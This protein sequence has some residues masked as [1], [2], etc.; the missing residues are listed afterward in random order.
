LNNKRN[1]KIKL[2]IDSL[3]EKFVAKCSTGNWIVEKKIMYLTFF[4]HSEESDSNL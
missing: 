2:D 1:K 3:P 4:F